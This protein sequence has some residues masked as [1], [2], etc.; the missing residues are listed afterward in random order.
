MRSR[1]SPGLSGRSFRFWTGGT[2]FTS[3][4]S[5]CARELMSLIRDESAEGIAMSNVVAP[6]LP[7]ASARLSRPPMTGTPEI[8]KRCVVGLSSKK[9]T[10]RYGDEGFRSKVLTIWIPPSPAPYTK[11]LVAVSSV[12]RRSCSLESRQT[13]RLAAIRNT[14]ANPPITITLRG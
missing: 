3:I 13:Y 11:I 7:R 6:V 5:F 1:I 9:P 12:G 10:G 14:P 8:L 2:I 4:P